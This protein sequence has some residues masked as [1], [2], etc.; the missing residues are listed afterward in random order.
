MTKKRY[1]YLDVARGL[2]IIAVIWGHITSHWSGNFVYLF[3]MPLFF[4]ISGML[5]RKEKYNSFYSFIKKRSKRLLVPYVIYSIVTWCVWACFNYFGHKDVD[6]YLAPLLQ[7]IFAQGSGQFF[8]HNSP[9]WFVPCLFAIEIMYFFISKYKDVYVI[10]ISSAIATLSMILEYCYGDSYLY[11][12]PW[13]FDAAMMALPFYATGNIAMRHLN[14]KSI[15]DWITSHKITSLFLV[16]ISFIVIG[17]SL[18]WFGS[19]SMGYSYYGNESMF[20]I[21]AFIGS[22]AT[23]ILSALISNSRLSFDTYKKLV[24]FLK[25]MGKVSLDV[26]CSHVPIKG[27]LIAFLAKI[28]H[29]ST[30]DIM[31]SVLLSLLVFAIT[32]VI[33]TMIVYVIKHKEILRLK[34]KYR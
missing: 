15:N 26:M 13:N 16:L 18:I 27:V 5:F 32:I 3:H 24:E 19:P 14:H 28:I 34:N 7:T 1:D 6:S 23:I 25:W 29:V 2:G 22:T 9:L 10:L 30:G 21:R 33:D 20:F 12:L 31:K 17:V 8:L 4:I 11:L